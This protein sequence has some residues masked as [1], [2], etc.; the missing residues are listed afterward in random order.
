MKFLTVF[1]VCALVASAY[2]ASLD[3][4]DGPVNFDGETRL[5]QDVL[6]LSYEGKLDLEQPSIRARRFTCDV[7]SFKSAWISP[8][9]S[10]CAVRCLAQN[11]KGGTCKNGNCECHD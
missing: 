1:A 4:Y 9:D 6:E 10:A 3:V 8:N 11:R 2:G 7:L 5:G